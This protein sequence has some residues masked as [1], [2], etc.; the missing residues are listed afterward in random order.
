MRSRGSGF[1]FFTPEHFPKTLAAIAVTS[2]CAGFY[3]M[4]VITRS[5]VSFYCD[6]LLKLPV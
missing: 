5:T 3:T 4:E 6:S 1:G 2:A